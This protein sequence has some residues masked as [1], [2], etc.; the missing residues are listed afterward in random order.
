MDQSIFSEE[1][2]EEINK[3]SQLPEEEQKQ[4]LPEFLKNLSQ[5]QLNALK[6]SQPQ[7]CPFCLIVEN[8]IKANKLYEDNEIIAALEI[9][10]AS[11][12]HTI[13]FPKKHIQILT[14]LNDAG[15]LFNVVNKLS[16]V[17]FETLNAQGTNILVSNGSAA[18]QMIPHL[19]VE[20]IPRFANDKLSFNLPRKKASEVELEK[21]MAK[22][23]SKPTFSEKPLPK[24]E[25]IEDKKVQEIK[26]EQN[27]SIRRER[28]P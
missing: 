28:L 26:K 25:V 19:I 6:Q 14:Q 3:I 8:K 11:L 7:Q 10:P 9:N 24:K 22:I 17:L 1:Q 23:K 16:S 20:I 15:K 5:E 4:L 18:G 21:V 2:I 13:V 12:G 27:K